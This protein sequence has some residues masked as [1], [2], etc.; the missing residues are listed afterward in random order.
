MRYHGHDEGEVEEPHVVDLEGKEGL[1][2]HGE[3]DEQD[4]KQ[5]LNYMVSMILVSTV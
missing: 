4:G 5:Y 1:T 2:V 3:Q